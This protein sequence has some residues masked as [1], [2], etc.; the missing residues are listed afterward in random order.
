MLADQGMGQATE[1]SL[2]K[3]IRL[4]PIVAERNA[5]GVNLSTVA[6]KANLTVPT[7]RRLLQGLV[8]GGLLS[9][10]PYSKIYTLGIAIFDLASAPGSPQEFGARRMDLHPALAE[11]AMIT[12]DT[13]YLTVLFGDEALCIDRASGAS[14]LSANTL[15]VGSRRPLGVG[16]GSAAILAAL[17][18]K[19][20]DQLIRSNSE[21]YGHYGELTVAEVR[22]MVAHWQEHRYLVNNSIIIPGV[23]AIAVAVFDGSDQ[24][25]AGLSVSTL[26]SRLGPQR[27]K[28]IVTVMTDALHRAGFKT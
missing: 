15:Q 10:D 17:P 21:T 25:V 7:A 11:T 20:R 26:K 18:E 19:R 16:A 6:R 13:A 24:L 14:P 3:A 22:R 28:D 1:T 2:A 12:G 23:S 4:L 9:F 27:R 8:D 5:T